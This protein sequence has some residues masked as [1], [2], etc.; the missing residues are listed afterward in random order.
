MYVPRVNAM[1]D[2]DVRSFVAAVGSAQLVTV[3]SDGS[4]YATQVPVVW[5]GDVVEA[6]LAVQNPHVEMIADGQEALM[7]VA[8]P[9]AYVSPQWYAAKATHGRVV[10]TWNYSTVQ[11]RGMVTVVRDPARLRES[12]ARLTDLHEA[13]HDHP[14]SVDDAPAAFIE[15]QLRGIVG[16]E[17]A[18]TEVSA[19]D[20]LS[21]NR[22]AED[23]AHVADGLA[24]RGG[25]DAQVAARMLRD[26]GT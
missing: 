25:R 8:G 20:K 17:I 26:S 7:I 12:V 23:R 9:E 18:V 11:I 13:G 15:G 3:A 1:P 6:H 4:P 5:N 24:A 19:K 16:V 14:W 10:P 22:S 21:Q 2:G